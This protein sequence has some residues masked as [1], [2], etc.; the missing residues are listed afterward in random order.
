MATPTRRELLQRI[1]QLESDNENL[2]SQL[3]EIADIVAPPEDQDEE[4]NQRED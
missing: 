3:D 4:D 1:E 2:Q